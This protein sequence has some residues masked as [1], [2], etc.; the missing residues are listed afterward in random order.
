M[1]D[2]YKFLDC[3]A[4]MSAVGAVLKQKDKNGIDHPVSYFS[5]C[6]SRAERNMCVARLELFSMIKL[7]SCV[8]RVIP[9]LGEILF[10]AYI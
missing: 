5:K 2:P 7:K 1:F 3:D 6:L 8:P 10:E 9:K 4:S